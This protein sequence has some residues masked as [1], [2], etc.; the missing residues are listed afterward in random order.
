MFRIPPCYPLREPEML[1]INFHPFTLVVFVALVRGQ[2]IVTATFTRKALG[3]AALRPYTL[4]IADNLPTTCKRFFWF[5][6]M[7]RG[8]M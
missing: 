8:F 5:Q 3:R 6:V 2:L 1:T 4:D 7:E